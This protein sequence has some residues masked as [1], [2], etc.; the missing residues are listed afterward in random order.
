MAAGRPVIAYKGG[1]ALEIIQQGITGLFFKEQ[2]SEDLIKVL[3]D[4]NESDFDP[5]TIRKKAI[6]FDEENFK[7]K[8]KEFI[9]RSI[10]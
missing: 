9:N 2:T 6:E 4:F 10:Q 5:K 3:K 8:I 1:G 7:E